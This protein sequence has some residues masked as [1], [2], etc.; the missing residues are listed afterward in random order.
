MD[1]KQVMSGFGIS[2]LPNI[3]KSIIREIDTSKI[4]VTEYLNEYIK[5]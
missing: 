3:N 2:I 5:N 1:V 4:T